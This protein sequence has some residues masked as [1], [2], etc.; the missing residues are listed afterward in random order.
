MSIGAFATVFL[1]ET[2]R[3]N[4]LTREVSDERIRSPR[5]E[6]NK[7]MT[8]PGTRDSRFSAPCMQIY[9]DKASQNET[10]AQFV[11]HFGAHDSANEDFKYLKGT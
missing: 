8:I 6:T 9:S 2:L 7:F 4:Y 11:P 5:E 1:N 10:P 3:S